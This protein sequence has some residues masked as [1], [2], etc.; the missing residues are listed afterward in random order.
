MPGMQFPY[1]R[2]S[3]TPHAYAST[4]PS[5]LR[6]KRW[7]RQYG[8]TVAGCIAIVWL[9]VWLFSGSASSTPY[10][11]PGTPE[12][13]IVTTLDPKL[14]EKFKEAIKENRRDY[15]QRHGYATFFPNTTD[16]DLMEKTPQSWSTIPGLR[17]AM[18]LYPHSQ[19]LWYLS[20][21]ALI[22]DSHESLQ[23]KLL[24]PR[25]LESLMITDK[26]VVPPDS[27]IRTFTHLKGER[28][29]FIITQDKEGLAGG[30]LLIRTGEWAKFFLDAWYDP[31]YRSYNFQKAE[32]HAL[33]HIVQ[34]HGTILAKLALV[35]QR[36]LN[37][38]TRE[39]SANSADG[40]Y[41]E[42]DFVANFHGCQRDP[43]RNCE[44][45]MNPLVSRWRELKDQ[46]HKR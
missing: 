8:P 44:E 14:P 12:V 19:W 40:L 4:R 33:E 20:S 35:P 27:V 21:T 34:W 31:L 9:L 42:G 6:N 38:Y 29:D 15:A 24:E 5:S 26:P 22:M 7:L 10:V 41:Q 46:E 18:T 32:G 43:K 45:E 36:V 23:T 16:Y 37:S 30:S 39:A 13:V 28:V 11:P 17:H 1:P 3:S 2:K 25:K